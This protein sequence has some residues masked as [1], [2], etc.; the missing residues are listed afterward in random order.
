MVVTQGRG[1]QAR[2]QRRPI[3]QR[4]VAGRRKR[5][6]VPTT[7]VHH[8]RGNRIQPAQRPWS[9]PV[10]AAAEH[11]TT[12]GRTTPDPAK[13]RCC[14]W[15]RSGY[16]VGGPL[17]RT[18]AI[19]RAARDAADMRRRLVAAA[20]E[21]DA[22]SDNSA[23]TQRRAVVAARPSPRAVPTRAPSPRH[24]RQPIHRRR[25]PIQRKC[26]SGSRIRA[27][28]G[29]YSQ[30]RFAARL[31]SARACI[32]ARSRRLIGPTTKT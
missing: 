24:R 16:S 20:L 17:G 25:L 6:A 27:G 29:G 5:S 7:S 26:R 13:F 32:S 14:R 19:I 18:S 30:A 8:L 2:F 4:L 12:R 31:L 22:A 23:Q 3:E 1:C 15:G 10:T 11:T 9:V 28:T 21:M